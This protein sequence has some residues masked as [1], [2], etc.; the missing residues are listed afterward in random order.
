MSCFG[1]RTEDRRPTCSDNLESFLTEGGRR[2]AGD[3][4]PGSLN[5]EC[6]MSKNDLR[7]VM[8]AGFKGVGCR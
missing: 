3:G 4:R 5:S 8:G 6:R 7:S 2:R 1:R